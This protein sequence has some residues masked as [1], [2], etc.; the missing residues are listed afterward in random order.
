MKQAILPWVP[1]VLLT[2]VIAVR[3][4]LP[5]GSLSQ[6]RI[7]AENRVAAEN[8]AI[9][10]IVED[11]RFFNV[12]DPF[13]LKWGWWSR[14]YEYEAILSSLRALGAHDGTRIHN[15]CWGW[16]GSHVLFK[17]VL[18]QDYPG[19]IHSDL[20]P[21][22]LPKTFVHDLRDPIPKEWVEAFDVVLNVSTVEEI[23]HSH[24]RIL[25]RLLEMTRA[26]GHVI[27]TFDFPGIQLDAIEGLFGRHIDMPEDPVT[28]AT[29]PYMMTEFND[30]MVG[31]LILKR[32]Q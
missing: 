31:C 3:R 7:S 26:G 5:F 21:S 20:R 6:R 4:S 29:S 15:T 17:Q 18:D 22:S 1:P 9:P 11:F 12:A 25:E 13:D 8:F 10:F 14:V 27:A 32:E 23:D 2:A 16:H 30:L 19:T 24:V 28:G